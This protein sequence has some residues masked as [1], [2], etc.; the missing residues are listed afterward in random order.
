MNVAGL[1]VFILMCVAG[2]AVGAYTFLDGGE[3]FLAIVAGCFTMLLFFLLVL[4]FV[5][6][7][8][9]ATLG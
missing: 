3:L 2:F 7:V 4:T 5:A 1:I 8:F 6:M 9:P